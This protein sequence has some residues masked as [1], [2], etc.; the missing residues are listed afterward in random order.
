[1]FERIYEKLIVAG[2][3]VLILALLADK[4][5]AP[6]AFSWTLLGVGIGLG[7]SSVFCFFSEEG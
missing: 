1:M 2:G 6:H 5:R 7:I 3:A 4:M